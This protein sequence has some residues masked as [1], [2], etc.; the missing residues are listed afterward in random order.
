MDVH[1]AFLHGDLP[2]EVYLKLPRGS[3]KAAQDLCVRFT[4]PLHVLSQ[5]L[6]APRQD[7]WTAALRVVK[8]L[9]GCQGQ[10][11]LLSANSDLQLT[12]EAE[13]RSMEAAA[14]D[15]K[16]LKGLLKLGVIHTCPMELLCDS[17]S[18]LYLTQNPVFYER[19][20]HIEIYCHFLLDGVL[21]G[22]IHTSHVHTTQQLA[23]IFTKVLGQKQFEFLLHKL[24]ILDLHAPI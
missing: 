21:D 10:G 6:H 15:L 20:K 2:E 11:I 16:W 19:T 24:D 13:Y 3:T 5:F 9:K 18:A 12:A 23:D 7:H 8:Y 14:C 22:T 4:S 1:N 17:Q